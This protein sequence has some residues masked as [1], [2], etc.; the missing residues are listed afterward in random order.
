[1]EVVATIE[2]PNDE[3]CT[4][5]EGECKLALTDNVLDGTISAVEVTFDNSEDRTD[6]TDAEAVLL[7]VDAADKCNEVTLRVMLLEAVLSW[8]DVSIV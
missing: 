6:A 2:V 8:V 3:F 5:T 7:D 1:M 4:I